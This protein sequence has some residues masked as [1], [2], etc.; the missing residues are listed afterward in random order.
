M[1]GQLYDPWKFREKGDAYR[2]AFCSTIRMPTQCKPGLG[3]VLLK[4]MPI[5]QAS[6]LWLH[7]FTYYAGGIVPSNKSVNSEIRVHLH[8]ILKV[9]LFV[10]FFL[11]HTVY[12][13]L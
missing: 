2:A 10:A 6:M 8:R 7:S 12:Q 4:I 11:G 13:T 9:V 1:F 3:V 5:C